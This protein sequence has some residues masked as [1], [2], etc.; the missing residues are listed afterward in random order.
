MKSV[1][2]FFRIQNVKTADLDSHPFYQN[3][4]IEIP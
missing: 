1:M 3:P 4:F 2:L